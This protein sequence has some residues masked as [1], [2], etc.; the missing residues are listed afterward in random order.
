[1]MNK[2]NHFDQQLSILTIQKSSLLTYFIS[3]VVPDAHCDEEGGLNFVEQ[4]TNTIVSDLMF[5]G[6]RIISVTIEK[7]K[8]LDRKSI[9]EICDNKLLNSEQDDLWVLE[10]IEKPIVIIVEKFKK[11]WWEVERAINRQLR[12]EKQKREDILHEFFCQ[13]RAIYRSVEKKQ[14]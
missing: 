9:Q 13:I 12:E 3:M 14:V 10:Y 1:M 8:K 11:L 5:N 6:Q 4:I 7:E 2:K